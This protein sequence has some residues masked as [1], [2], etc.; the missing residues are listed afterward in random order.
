[1][2]RA[3]NK[4][5]GGEGAGNVECRVVFREHL[6]GGLSCWKH[7]VGGLSCWT[8][9]CGWVRFLGSMCPKDCWKRSEEGLIAGNETGLSYVADS[10]E[11]VSKVARSA[12]WSGE[13]S[14]KYDTSGQGAGNAR[15][16]T[17]L[18]ATSGGREGPGSTGC[19]NAC[20]KRGVW[21]RD[22][23]W[24]HRSRKTAGNA[25]WGVGE[26]YWKLQGSGSGNVN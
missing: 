21:G 11:W 2:L 20:W 6:V 25:E 24:K 13:R 1:M 16:T 14:W 7:I 4:G 5:L 8:Q 9:L 19:R 17:A 3:G 23:C 26:S 22:M 10:V 15:R 12:A 18:I